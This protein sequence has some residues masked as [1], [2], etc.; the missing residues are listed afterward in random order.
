MLEGSIVALITPFTENYNINFKKLYE[1]IEYQYLSGTNALLILGTTSESSTLSEYECDQIVDF[2]IKQNN[3]RMKIVVGVITNSTK[4][5]ILKAIKYESF[6]A[7]Y[8]LVN[9]P[10]YNKTNKRGLIKHFNMIA[11]SVK[12][13]IILYN[14]PSRVGMNI[15]V[16]I[17]KELKENANIIGVKESNKDINHILDVA[18]IC[19]DNFSLYCGNDDLSYFFLSIGAKGLINVYGNIEPKVIRN[20]I[21][22]YMENTLLAKQYFFIY[23]KIF[24]VIF[25]ETNPIP[26]KALMNYKGLNV[27]LY[28]LPLDE[29]D[30]NNYKKM[31]ETY[32]EVHS[33]RYH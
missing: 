24:K 4:A 30:E 26:I 29:M 23:Y 3:K 8:L 18:N 19:D 12:I 15:D 32:I 31:I 25:I 7:D 1:M 20:L 16:D 6:G 10:Y 21:N 2:V 22:I 27:G 13:P 11:S 28:R 14:I 17:M 9:P 5:S 33:N